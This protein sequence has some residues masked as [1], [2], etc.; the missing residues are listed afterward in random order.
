MNPIAA[1]AFDYVRRL[2]HEMSGVALEPSK[3]YLVKARLAPVAEREGYVSI[4][5][6]VEE[7]KRR[8]R[9]HMHAR[10]V[11]AMLTTETSFFRDIHPFTALRDNV[12][13]RL[14]EAR[15]TSRSL[16]IWSAACSSGQEPYSIALLINEHFPELRYWD[17]TILASD[18]SQSML[19]RARHGVF[20]QPEINR[21]VPARMIVKHFTQQGVRWKINEELR[22]AVSFRQ[23]NLGEPWPPLPAM[24]I[25]LLRNV[26]IYFD[27]NV[28]RAVLG[29]IRHILRPDGYL[30][31]GAAE[32][33]L[34]SENG[35]ASERLCRTTCY[36]LENTVKG[37]THGVF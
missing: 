18:L 6:M 20:S 8:P 13:P 37:A 34:G 23:I 1:D 14:I 26:L 24:D 25:V 36:R 15:R 32:T 17:V 4:D 16:S 9:N 2:V 22:Q 30:F 11:D 31:L 10:L 28:R 12:L 7:L 33:S 21:G 5:Q 3:E 19:S 35:F 27:D 29:R